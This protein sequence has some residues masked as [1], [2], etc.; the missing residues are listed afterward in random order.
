MS[1]ETLLILGF[2]LLSL[3]PTTHHIHFLEHFQQQVNLLAGVALEEDIYKEARQQ[4]EDDLAH[5][6]AVETATR[7]LEEILD[8][9]RTPERARSPVDAYIT[10]SCVSEDV[11][12]WERVSERGN[13]INNNFLQYFIFTCL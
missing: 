7:L 11:G 12:T 3:P 2:V 4:I 5:R 10:V 9:V 8:G 6:E 1:K 13:F